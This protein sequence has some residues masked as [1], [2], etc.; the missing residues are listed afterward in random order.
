[1]ITHRGIFVAYTF[2]ET[3]REQPGS[4][5][6]EQLEFPFPIQYFVF[7]LSMQQT[8]KRRCWLII[9]NVKEVECHKGIVVIELFWFWTLI[10]NKIELLT[11]F[12]LVFLH[13]A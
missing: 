5:L 13:R 8:P 11:W 2:G 1:M 10:V 6:A 4:E 3:G 12:Q 7:V 9:L